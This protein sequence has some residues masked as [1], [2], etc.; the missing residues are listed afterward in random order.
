MKKTRE[1]INIFSDEGDGAYEKRE[2]EL[3]KFHQYKF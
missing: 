1:N 2:R 3:Y